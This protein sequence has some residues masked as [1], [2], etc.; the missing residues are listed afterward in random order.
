VGVEFVERLR[1]MEK[2]DRVE[3]LVAQMDADV[4]KTRE[5]IG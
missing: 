2:F 1:G 3:D 4:R 5:R